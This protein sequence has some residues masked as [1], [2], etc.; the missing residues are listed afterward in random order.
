MNN[1]QNQGKSTYTT[2]SDL[3]R[4]INDF[5][6]YTNFSVDQCGKNRQQYEGATGSREVLVN[7]AT[8]IFYDFLK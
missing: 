6:I 7:T 8:N 5:Y 1:Q 3:P 4:F 2:L